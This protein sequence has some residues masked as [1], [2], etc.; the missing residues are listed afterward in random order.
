MIAQDRRARRLQSVVDG[1]ANEPLA[2]RNAG[3]SHDVLKNPQKRC[4]GHHLYNPTPLQPRT[5]V[6]LS[7]GDGM[8]TAVGHEKT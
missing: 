6:E 3:E 5:V 2:G 8:I 1:R 7:A 4:D